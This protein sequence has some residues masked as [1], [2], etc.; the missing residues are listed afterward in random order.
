MRHY[1]RHAEWIT[2]STGRHHFLDGAYPI[3]DQDFDYPDE[4]W[5]ADHFEAHGSIA[6]EL[7]E[8]RA[9]FEPP[10]DRERMQ[11]LTALFSKAT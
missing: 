11:R 9:L 3:L 4:M 5:V 2:T 10:P 7:R 6:T 1:S 8:I